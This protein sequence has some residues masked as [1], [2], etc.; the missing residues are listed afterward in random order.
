MKSEAISH[1]EE[2]YD[3]TL[4]FSKNEGLGAGPPESG[5]KL[6]EYQNNLRTVSENYLLKDN[7]LLLLKD[8]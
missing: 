2:L 5:S 7:L 3:Q 8:I 6:P 1:V 4:E